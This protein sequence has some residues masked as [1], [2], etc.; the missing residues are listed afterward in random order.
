M[1]ET[2]EL[3]ASLEA[4]FTPAPA[5]WRSGLPPPPQAV[6]QIPRGR[7]SQAFWAEGMSSLARGPGKTTHES[8]QGPLRGK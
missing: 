6:C 3:S 1:P 5:S 7:V 8:N 4:T 2:G